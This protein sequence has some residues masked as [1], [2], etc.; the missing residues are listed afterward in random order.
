M[1]A[2]FGSGEEPLPGI[3]V[4]PKVTHLIPRRNGHPQKTLLCLLTTCRTARRA[5]AAMMEGKVGNLD[6]DPHSGAA[7][8]S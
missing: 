2:R 1:P 8:C 6:F 5:G 7:G 4:Q 3:G